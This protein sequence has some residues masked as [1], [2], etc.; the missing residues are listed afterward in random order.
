MLEDFAGAAAALTTPWVQRIRGTGTESGTLQRNG[1]G[2][3]QVLSNGSAYSASAYLGDQQYGP[4]QEVYDTIT[5]K[6]GS[7]NPSELYLCIGNP[8]SASINAYRLYV[9]DVGA[10]TDTWELQRI[11]ANVATTLG[12]VVNQEIT[13]LD[14][15]G[16]SYDAPTLT[17]WYRSGA[18]GSWSSLFTRS[19]STYTTG[20]YIGLGM[21]FSTGR[22]DNFGGGTIVTAQALMNR[23]GVRSRGGSW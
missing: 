10:G 23:H 1:S 17:A 6:P 7:G 14:G 11:D 8:A 16:M 13:A 22:V 4:A 20:G 3:C 19:D 15:I 9:T 5:T 12:A 18:G 21:W 2:L